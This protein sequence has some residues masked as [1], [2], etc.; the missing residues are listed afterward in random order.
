MAAKTS[1]KKGSKRYKPYEGGAWSVGGCKP[2][3]KPANA[4]EAAQRRQE[5]TSRLLPYAQARAAETGRGL[6][7]RIAAFYE[8]E[9][10]AL[11]AVIAAPAIQKRAAR[12]RA[13]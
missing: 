1:T 11:E 2:Y 8:A 6:Y 12:K 13:A 7:Q 5:I 9:L 3:P 10:I 4:I